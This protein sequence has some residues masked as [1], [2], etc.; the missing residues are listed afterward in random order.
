MKL[1]NLFKQ[2][3][4]SVDAAAQ[5]DIESWPLSPKAKPLLAM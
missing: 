4:F 5:D 3:F 1:R 2:F